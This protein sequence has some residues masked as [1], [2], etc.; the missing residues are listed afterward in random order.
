VDYLQEKIDRLKRFSLGKLS[1]TEGEV[2]QC[3]REALGHQGRHCLLGDIPVSLTDV[4]TDL[5]WLFDEIRKGEYGPVKVE[6]TKDALRKEYIEKHG[7][8]CETCNR[9]PVNHGQRASCSYDT[10]PMHYGYKEGDIICN[11][12]NGYPEYRVATS[13]YSI[14]INYAC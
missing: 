3:L 4:A 1:M 2:R 8:C 12:E 11:E 6:K 5:K 9:E 13:I 7:R 10:G 14:D